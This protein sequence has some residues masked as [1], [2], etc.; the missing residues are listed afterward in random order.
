MVIISQQYFL[1]SLA[2]LIPITAASIT[3]IARHPPQMIVLIS[4]YTIPAMIGLDNPLLICATFFPVSTTQPAMVC[5]KGYD[6]IK[7]C[8]AIGEKHF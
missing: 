2:T 6:C 5:V 4:Q 3:A 7:E 1:Y 8:P